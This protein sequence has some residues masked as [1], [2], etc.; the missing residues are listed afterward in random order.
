MN[1]EYRPPDR[2][3]TMI[4]GVLLSVHSLSFLID[5]S[6]KVVAY[7]DGRSRLLCT[8]VGDDCYGSPARMI[9]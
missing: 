9:A 5:S 6:S 7:D 3:D 1:F 4:S 2:G 8:C